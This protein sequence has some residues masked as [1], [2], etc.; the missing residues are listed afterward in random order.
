MLPPP[1]QLNCIGSGKAR[2]QCRISI[3]L[4]CNWSTYSRRAAKQS[5]LKWHLFCLITYAA[6][7]NCF[8][9]LCA[10]SRVVSVWDAR[11]VADRSQMSKTTTKKF[12]RENVRP[13]NARAFHIFVWCLLKMKTETFRSFV[14]AKCSYAVHC[15]RLEC[16]CSFVR[17][18]QAINVSATTKLT[19]DCSQ[20]TSDRRVFSFTLLKSK[21][22][23]FAITTHTHCACSARNSIFPKNHLPP[24]VTTHRWIS[25]KCKTIVRQNDR[26]SLRKIGQLV[27]LLH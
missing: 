15:I 4:Y 13:V 3:R 12:V 17:N 26:A 20:V 27:I 19:C 11:N 5:P 14:G 23:I 7:C 21:S 9:R 24:S 2:S 16:C 18:S 22:H 25:N 1:R 10:V 8:L 6:I